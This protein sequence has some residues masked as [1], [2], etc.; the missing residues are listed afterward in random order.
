MDI[1][2]VKE[3]ETRFSQLTDET[4]RQIPQKISNT[5]KTICEKI[6]IAV[7]YN[8]KTPP[9]NRL[10]IRD[11]E[12][13]LR[14]NARKLG[15]NYYH[16]ASVDEVLTFASVGTEIAIQILSTL[17]NGEYP[18]KTDKEF[19]L[20]IVSRLQEELGDGY[21]WIDDAFHF[22][23]NPLLVNEPYLQLI[24]TKNINVVFPSSE[25]NRLLTYV[26]GE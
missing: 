20:Y 16:G 17:E 4:M 2:S 19:A 8:D 6:G 21:P 22:V 11:Y 14:R 23:C 5:I 12:Y 9:E 15:R 18:W 1:P 26:K 24:I 3:P 10:D 25:L 7:E 13:N